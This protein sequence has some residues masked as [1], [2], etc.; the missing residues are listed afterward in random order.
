LLDLHPEPVPPRVEAHQDGRATD[1]GLLDTAANETKVIAARAKLASVI[2][3]GLFVK[4]R[5]TTFEF[6]YYFDSVDTWL[7]YMADRWVDATIDPDL[8]SR[9]R[10]LLEPAPGE[11]VLREQ[12]YASR[13]ERLSR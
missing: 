10:Q 6:R 13:L 8:V 4:T 5:S 12:V 9:A 3:S 2:G 1:V 11:L 7:A